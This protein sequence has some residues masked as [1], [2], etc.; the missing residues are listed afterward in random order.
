MNDTLKDKPTSYNIKCIIILINLRFFLDLFH[1]R[2]ITW[3]N[4]DQ[5][6]G[7]LINSCIWNSSTT[8][9][10]AKFRCFHIFKCFLLYKINSNMSVLKLTLI[11]IT[12]E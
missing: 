5:V 9:I 7:K 4:Q 3:E 10:I 6:T 12:E 2:H 1:Y 8:E 11:S